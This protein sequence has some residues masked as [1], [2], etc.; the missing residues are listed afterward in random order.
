[1]FVMGDPQRL[2]TP[3]ERLE[4]LLRDR[5]D[6]ACYYPASFG[7]A[8]WD[9][10]LA[11][12]PETMV[13]FGVYRGYSSIIAALAM[14][15]VGRG[16]VLAYDNWEDRVPEGPDPQAI[17]Q[18]H[19][20]AYGVGH[21]ITLRE[22]EFGDW[23]ANPEECDLL[24]LDIDNDGEKV[25]SMFWGLRARIDRGLVVLFEGGSEERDQH[26]VMAGRPPIGAIQ[27]ETGYEVVV[28][29]FPSLSRIAR[30]ASP[31]RT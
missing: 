29:E 10:V 31:V 26:P 19:I 22:R 14:E 9:A 23:I 2:A 18:Y 15:E 5:G 27:E 11:V 4:C 28:Q 30:V 7:T 16:R 3:R 24:Y 25:G 6:V 21:R 12:R 20:D 8:I 1:M 13:N 17:A